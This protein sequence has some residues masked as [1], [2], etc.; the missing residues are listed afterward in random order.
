MCDATVEAHVWLAVGQS[1]C[2]LLSGMR[3]FKQVQRYAVSGP[4]LHAIQQL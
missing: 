1:S 3:M 4:M 2:L